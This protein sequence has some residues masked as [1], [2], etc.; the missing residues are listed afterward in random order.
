M[1]AGSYAMKQIEDEAALVK[2]KQDAIEKAELRKQ[3][4]IEAEK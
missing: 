3:D 1:R 2:A 4:K